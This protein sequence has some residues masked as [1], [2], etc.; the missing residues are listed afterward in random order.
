MVTAMH[1]ALT[2]WELND[3]VHTVVLTGAGERGLRAGGDVV[4]TY[5]SAR[6]HRDPP[7]LVQ[8]VPA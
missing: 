3:D 4:A 7:L 1:A 6:R 2:D 8:R 5:Q